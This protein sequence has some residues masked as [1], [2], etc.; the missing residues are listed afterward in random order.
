MQ[1][2]STFLPFRYKG[3]TLL[4][5]SMVI[6]ILGILLAFTIPRLGHLTEYNLNVSCRRLSGAVK[7][8]FHQSTVHRTIYRLN[9]DLKA[10]EYWITYRDE[11]LEF[12]RDAS[13]LAR[14]VKLPKNVSFDDVVIMGKGKFTEGQIQTHFF[15]KGWLDETLIHLKDSKG[16]QASIHILPLSARAKIYNRYVDLEIE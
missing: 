7:Y 13:V 9:Y 5:L 12:V 8:L 11:N 14:K 1:W 4:E 16:R 15:P 2:R 3:F 6:L 10:N